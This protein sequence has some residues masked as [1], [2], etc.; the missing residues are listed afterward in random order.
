MRE[1][2]GGVAF[3]SGEKLKNV[4]NYFILLTLPL[5]AARILSWSGFSHFNPKIMAWLEVTWGRKDCIHLHLFATD[6]TEVSQSGNLGQNLKQ[7]TQK[8]D[9]LHRLYLACFPYVL[10]QPLSTFP[11]WHCQQ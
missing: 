10:F 3:L 8:N 2:N 1:S 5:L 4:V 9:T 6:R 11:G 7:R